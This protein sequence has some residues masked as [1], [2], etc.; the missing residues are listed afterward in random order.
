MSHYGDNT[1]SRNEQHFVFCALC[2][3][4]EMLAGT[5]AA[6][7]WITQHARH[8]HQKMSPYSN[9]ALRTITVIYEKED[10]NKDQEPNHTDP[11]GAFLEGIGWMMAHGYL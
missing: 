8:T 10:D 5:A 3:S 2:R 4:G 11:T 1:R 7:R 9:D 6:E